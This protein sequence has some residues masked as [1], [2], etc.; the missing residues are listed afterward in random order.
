MRK[1]TVF[2]TLLLFLN[3][4]VQGCG[5][6]ESLNSKIE[7][8]EKLSES[9][10]EYMVDYMYDAMSEIEVI[11]QT[12]DPSDAQGVMEAGREVASEYPEFP[13]YFVVCTNAMEEKDPAIENSALDRDK[14]SRVIHCVARGWDM[15]W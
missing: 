3:L 10:Y 14:F 1:K 15:F 2:F 5:G 8:N 11:N 12:Y 4:L 6:S 13:K 7:K 9:D